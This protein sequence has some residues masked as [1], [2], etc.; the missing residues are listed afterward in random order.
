MNTRQTRCFKGFPYHQKGHT[1]YDSLMFRNFPGRTPTDYILFD[2]R[3]PLK[4][5]SDVLHSIVAWLKESR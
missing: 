1:R 2:N 5:S 3:R 4:D